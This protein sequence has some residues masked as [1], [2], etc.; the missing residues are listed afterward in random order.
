MLFISVK[1]SCMALKKEGTRKLPT[2]KN[3][4]H[5]YGME[6][7]NKIAEKYNGDFAFTAENNIADASV[8]LEI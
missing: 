8:M 6:I 1:N 5:G 2:T 7:I 4:D 3:G